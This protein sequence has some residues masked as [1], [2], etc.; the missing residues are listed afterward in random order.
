MSFILNALR[1]SE[2]ERQA[3]QSEAVTGR[4]LPPQPQKNRNKTTKLFVSLIIANVL[5]IAC[6]AWLVHNGS[7]QSPDTTVQTISIPL[8]AQVTKIEAKAI[9]KS[10]QPKKAESKT[11]SIA[12][13]NNV[14]KPEPASLPI[15][16]VTTK[17]PVTDTMKQPTIANKAGLSKQ[18]T[19]A[20]AT[21]VN[22][23]PVPPE[24][25][26]VKKDIP[27]LSDL[28]LEFQQTIPKL[29]INVF[30]YSQQPEESFVIIDMVKYKPGQQIKD[31]MILKEI[32]PDSLIVALQNQAF[33]I[34]RP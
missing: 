2:Q 6:I 13:W 18:T 9:A 33:K 4:I 19:P 11:T 14:Q 12:E 16:P 32:L 10:A 34:K 5:F 31:A 27:L 29:T 3:L 8:S 15:K 25:N 24:P 22:V 26:P 7:T 28:P 23:Q 1:K 30:V 17:S 20:M 21:T